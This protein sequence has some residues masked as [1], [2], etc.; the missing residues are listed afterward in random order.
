MNICI[1]TGRFA[2]D[3]EVKYGHTNTAV[4]MFTLA[5]DRDYKRE[6]GATADFLNYKAFGKT[7]EFIEKYFHKGTKANI[8]AQLQ[9]D[10]YKK[11]DGTMVYRDTLIVQKIEFGESKASGKANNSATEQAPASSADDFMSIPDGMETVP[12]S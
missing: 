7:A 9:N 1:H 3:P 6:G 5:V 8:T 10:N 11:P 4:A 2:K 12:F